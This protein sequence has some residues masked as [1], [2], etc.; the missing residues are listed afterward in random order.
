M[1]KECV[2]KTALILC[3][4]E[5]GQ[6]DALERRLIYSAHLRSLTMF[7]YSGV[8]VRGNDEAGVAASGRQLAGWTL[9]FT[10]ERKSY[11]ENVTPFG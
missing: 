6:V 10:W 8:S 9:I 4:E 7:L 11:L 5:G 3:I 1:S 2:E